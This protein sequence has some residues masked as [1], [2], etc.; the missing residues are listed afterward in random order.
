MDEEHP[1]NPRSPVR[2]DE[3]GRRPARV[4]LLR[5][6]RAADRD[7]AARSTTTG[8]GSIR[9]RSCRASSRRRSSGE[10]L[11]IH[12]DGHASRDWLYVDDDAEAIEALIA[13]DIDGLA[14]EV[15]N[16]ATGVDISVRDIADSVLEAVGAD[17]DV[18]YV[19]ERPGQVDRH[20]GST[21]K[22]E[23]LT[24][25]RARTCF[26]QRARAHGRVVPRERGVVAGSD[27]ARQRLLVLGAGPAQLGLLRAA[28]ERGLFVI[29]VDRD[30][31]GAGLRATRT[32]ARSSRRRT[33]RA[34]SGSRGPRTSTGSS[35]PAPTGRSASPRGSPSGSALPHPIDAATAAL[36]T[37][38]SRQRE[39]FAEAGV[40]QPR[41]RSERAASR[42]VRRQGARP[43]GPAR[44]HARPHRGG[45]A[46]GDR[47]RASPRRATAPAS[48]RSSSTARR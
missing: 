12:G 30:P 36:A 27:R 34:S 20:I 33:S 11:T 37:T 6:L 16:V 28:R 10:P 15:V 17:A 48:S 4:Q 46:G 23:R 2:G 26:E 42:P 1:L 22:L 9:R 7:R 35:R 44:P 18:V 14:G 13:A 29:A 5:H 25:W 40:P 45:A 41:R 24:G 39:R 32:S 21:D 3:G 47:S 43:P 38:K 31:R 8:R 19:E